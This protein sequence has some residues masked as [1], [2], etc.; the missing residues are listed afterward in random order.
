[1]GSDDLFSKRKARKNDALE[2]QKKERARSQRFLIV[3]E[4]TKTEPYYLKEITDDLGIKP[5]VVKVAPND[6][7]SPDRVVA[8]ALKLYEED[9]ICGDSFDRVYCVFDRDKHDTFDAAVQ[10][11][12]ELKEAKN[13]KPF[14][15]ITSVPCF[16]YWL[17]LHFGLTDQPFRAAGKKSVCDRLMSVLRTKPGFKKYDKGQHGIYGLLKDKTS[18]AVKG[19]KQVRR[20]ATKTGQ[21]DPSTQIDILVEAL[22]LLAKN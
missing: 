1:M 8:H 13:P 16:E 6:G 11:T 14:E 20:N 22:Q 2:R 17:L 9:A 4:G 12:K 19:A 15:A 10:K 21:D 18:I 7:A 3:C 5:Q